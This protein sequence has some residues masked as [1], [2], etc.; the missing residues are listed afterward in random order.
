M[1]DKYFLYSLLTASEGTLDFHTPTNTI[2][3][4]KMQ[5]PWGSDDSWFI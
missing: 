2:N 3:W 5:R 1:S 4:G